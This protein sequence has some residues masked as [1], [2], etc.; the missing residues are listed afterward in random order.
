MLTWEI[1]K[2]HLNKTWL[3]K[4]FITSKLDNIINKDT[5]A[6]TQKIMDLIH[7]IPVQLWEDEDFTIDM[8]RK[9]MNLSHSGLY[10]KVKAVSGQSINSFIRLIRLRKA[11]VLLLSSNANVS[12]AALQVGIADVKYFRKQFVKL[13]GMPPTEY[14]KKYKSSFNK[15]FNV[16]ENVRK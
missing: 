12:E 2:E 11:A 3:N 1:T 4:E 16:T 7:N 14:V 5:D 8:M 9:E 15:E 13:F 10:K 6:K